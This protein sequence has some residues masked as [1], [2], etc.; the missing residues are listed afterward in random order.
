MADEFDPELKLNYIY[1]R[2]RVAK[3]NNGF[4]VWEMKKNRLAC[5][6]FFW[7]AVNNETN[8]ID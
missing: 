2:A 3:N 7:I 6:T 8:R 1:R 4:S 5:K